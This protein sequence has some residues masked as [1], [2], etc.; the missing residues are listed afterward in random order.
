[1]DK[2]AAE[3]RAMEEE[4]EE[5]RKKCQKLEKQ[6][7]VKEKQ[8]EIQARILKDKPMVEVL[9]QGI[10]QVITHPNISIPTSNHIACEAIKSNFVFLKEECAFADQKEIELVGSKLFH[11]TKEYHVRN[12]KEL[13]SVFKL[14]LTDLIALCGLNGSLSYHEEAGLTNFYP[15]F[16]LVTQRGQ[17]KGVIEIK[18]PNSKIFSQPE[19]KVYG[20]IYD[21][22]TLLKEVHNL[23]QV[24][25]ILSSYAETIIVWLDN[26]NNLVNAD[27]V[28]NINQAKENEIALKKENPLLVLPEVLQK[29]PEKKDIKDSQVEELD[30]IIYRSDIIKQDD[31]DFAR[32]L[33]SVIQKMYRCE[34]NTET[35]S[36]SR[37]Y[38]ELA[39]GS[40]R[41]IHLKEE[42]VPKYSSLISIS[43][44]TFK[45]T[46]ILLLQSL[47]GGADG[48]CW[49]AL[50]YSTTEV[51]V[52]K[53]FKD[54]EKV[55]QEH[56]IWKDVWDINTSILKLNRANC[57]AMPFFKS[58]TDDDWSNHEFLNLV[59]LACERFA[60]AKYIHKDL[61]RRHV[62]KYKE[63]GQL[64]IVFIDLAEV[65]QISKDKVKSSS[66]LMFKSLMQD[67]QTT[68]TTVTSPSNVQTTFQTPHK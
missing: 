7:D 15:D 42:V 16:I 9:K 39:E 48:K 17:P 62:M 66:E 30:R 26:N 55:H 11:Q 40:F 54:P 63:N 59:K 1:M 5:L 3:K 52:L 45:C 53:F 6:I 21:Y 35:G 58:S 47:G 28:S 29:K 22:M 4:I 41:W 12:E 14:L 46:K 50:N 38:V 43:D 37:N 34:V 25:G 49:L 33:C 31:K 32:K 51:L 61:V 24:F 60:E 10:A 13:K 65:G 8:I 2:E 57:L 19:N 44:E 20:Q 56:R 68:I 18:T 36:P 67:E 64:K 27:T 23:K